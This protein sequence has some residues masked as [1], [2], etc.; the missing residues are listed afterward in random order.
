ML[1][2]CNGGGP[3]GDGTTTPPAG[4]G[5][6]SAPMIALTLAG[7]PGLSAGSI[8]LVGSVRV[9][10]T[11]FDYTY[12]ARATNGTGE[13]LQNVTAIVTSDAPTTVVTDSTLAFGGLAAGVSATSSDT[14]TIRQDRVAPLA[15]ANLTITLTG[16]PVIPGPAE[17]VLLQGQPGDLAI[18]ALTDMF[19]IPALDADIENGVIL[20]RVD[21]ALLGDATVGEVNSALQSVGGGIVG[22]R[23]GFPTVVVAVPR[24]TDAAALQ[25]LAD[26][27]SA[28][29]GINFALIGREDVAN[30]AP[31]SPAN[32][33]AA[34]RH[35]QDSRF[36]AAWNVSSLAGGCTDRPVVMVADYFTRP[37]PGNSAYTD[38]LIEVPSVDGNG[39]GGGGTNPGAGFHGYDVT[40]T[41]A[42]TL[43]GR[44]P[45]GANPFP[46]CLD[47]RTVQL[48][49]LTGTGV[50][51]GVGAS[52]PPTGKVVVNTSIGLLT[53][54]DPC[55][56][57][58][59]EAPD[60]LE[61]GKAAADVRAILAPL[62]DRVLITAAAGNEA[63]EDIARIYPGTALADFGGRFNA[64]A[65]ADP[66]LSFTADR[67]LWEPTRQACP[68]D[69]CFPSLTVTPD[70]RAELNDYVAAL[71]P[72][73][74]IPAANVLIVGSTQPG[75]IQRSAFSNAGEDVSAVGE[76]I[77]TMVN[78]G[79]TQGTSFAA[80]Q[81]AGLASFL[82]MVSP[83]LRGRPLA[84]TISAI[85][86]NASEPL[87][88][89][90]AYATVLSLDPASDPDP[91]TW[92]VRRTLLDVSEDGQFTETDIAAFIPRYFEEPDLEVEVQ[93]TSRDYSRYDLNGDGYTGDANRREGFDLDRT[94]S[95]QFGAPVLDALNL[96]VGTERRLIS[97]AS[98][99]DLDILCYYAY[100]ALFQGSETERE[101]LLANK[102]VNISVVVTPGGAMVQPGGTVNFAADV[103]GTTDPRVNWSLPNGGGTITAAGVFTAGTGT[104]TFTVRAA[105]VVDPNAFGEASVTVVPVL[106]GQL[107]QTY[108]AEY[109]VFGPTPHSA[110]RSTLSASITVQMGANETFTVL[111]ASGTY[112]GVSE[113]AR[114][115][116]SVGIVTYSGT[117]GPADQSSIGG[118]SLV[119]P[120]H[121]TFTPPTTQFGDNVIMSFTVIR[122]QDGQSIVALDFNSNVT[123]ETPG[124]IGQSIDRT[125]IITTGRLEVAP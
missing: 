61:R 119:V 6:N 50:A 97:E 113:S 106:T 25:A 19:P 26:G 96:Q 95:V 57:D 42:A 102:C 24:Q 62:A 10:R 70:E 82:W 56:P 75:A 45:T 92:K 17:G 77:P 16:D 76:G 101:R 38:F 29:A 72:A 125:T 91:A 122:S 52:V 83:E 71:G 66:D 114:P 87:N 5:S 78:N 64:A 68:G 18:S 73:G 115:G 88:Q 40:T 111:E 43:D 21:V 47:I 37:I 3:G 20:T 36:P 120:I 34:I 65:R 100:S 58:Q 110:F 109:D 39:I 124:I 15:A 31:P 79:T 89:I 22:M 94:G 103:R 93:P 11:V 32:A 99:T 86:A 98:A 60:A 53:C 13:A 90:D 123:E 14:F 46:E 51:I 27:L 44:V 59:L 80:P 8:T 35:L 116:G 108:D 1:S 85:T 54:S 84:D 2:A 30:I 67:A 28:A 12:T 118:G 9:S 41:L 55:T 48:E 7:P 69:P 49:G 63:D 107:T 74:R 33:E 121:G 4:D 105:S 104:G 23:A 117:V 81:A 112:S